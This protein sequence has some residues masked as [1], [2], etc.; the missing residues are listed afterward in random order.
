LSEKSNHFGKEISPM[1]KNVVITC[2]ML[3]SGT[4]SL[5]FG[6]RDIPKVETSLTKE[7][8]N[9]QPK[10]PRGTDTNWQKVPITPEII[11]R[12]MQKPSVPNSFGPHIQHFVPS[13]TNE[14]LLHKFFNHIFVVPN[15]TFLWQHK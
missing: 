1:K 11:E 12:V 4:P 15:P 8:K 3:L 14:G 6:M 9:F 13:R 7:Y 5:G 2:I 10:F